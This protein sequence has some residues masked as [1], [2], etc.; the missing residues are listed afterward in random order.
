MSSW[1]GLQYYFVEFYKW[2][3]FGSA[4][5]RDFKDMKEA[6][7]R[8]LYA[9]ILRSQGEKVYPDYDIIKKYIDKIM[10]SVEN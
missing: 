6:V 8:G 5:F 7:A 3:F 2:L 9:E 1:K 4:E 10:E